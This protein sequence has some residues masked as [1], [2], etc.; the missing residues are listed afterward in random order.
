MPTPLTQ[1]EIDEYIKL[2]GF[3]PSEATLNTFTGEVTPKVK[4]QPALSTPTTAE[5]SKKET[6]L[7]SAALSLGP[8]AASLPVGAAVGMKAAAMSAPL[9]AVP[10]IGPALPP[11]IGIGSGLIAGGLAGMGAGA[12]QQKVLEQSQTGQEFLNRA[13]L[14]R[15]ANPIT[16]AVGDVAGSI[17]GVRP[18]PKMMK[19]AFYALTGAERAAGA[20]LANKLMHPA[21]QEIGISGALGGGMS[22]Y[23]DIQE[24]KDVNVGKAL[25]NTIGQGIMSNVHPVLSRNVPG[26]RGTSYTGLPGAEPRQDMFVTER[27]VNPVEPTPEALNAIAAERAGLGLKLDAIEASMKDVSDKVRLKQLQRE[28]KIKL[29]EIDIKNKELEAREQVLR[30]KVTFEA[31]PENVAWAEQ[32]A[33]VKGV[34]DFEA[35]PTGV[36]KSDSGQSYGEFTIGP[37][38][39]RSIRA[40]TTAAE[41]GPKGEITTTLPE[42]MIQERGAEGST[43]PSTYIGPRATTLVHENFHNDFVNMIRSEKPAQRKMGSQIL[44]AV[45]RSPEFT[46]WK[47]KLS[48][49]ALA[50][51]PDPVEELYTIEASKEFFRDPEN[52]SRTWSGERKALARLQKGTGT[53]QDAV[54]IGLMKFR[55]DRGLNANLANAGATGAKASLASDVSAEIARREKNPEMEQ[56]Q[57]PKTAQ[58]GTP[59][60]KFLRDN[61]ELPKDTFLPKK[62]QMEMRLSQPAPVTKLGSTTNLTI[63]TE[64]N[65]LK[66]EFFRK[67]PLLT[68]IPANRWSKSHLAE[69]FGVDIRSIND[70]EAR[71]KA[72]N[73]TAPDWQDIIDKGQYNPKTQPKMERNAEGKMRAVRDEEGNAVLSDRPMKNVITD[74]T[75]DAVRVIEKGVQRAIEPMKGVGHGTRRAMIRALESGDNIEFGADVDY[76]KMLTN[77]VIQN[78]SQQGVSVEGGKTGN[79]NLFMSAARETQRLLRQDYMA[80]REAKEDAFPKLKAER[81]NRGK[82]VAESDNSVKADEIRKLINDNFKKFDADEIDSDVYESVL[83]TQEAKL[84]ELGYSRDEIM[85]IVEDAESPEFSVEKVL[86]RTKRPVED[87]VEEEV[88]T[89]R[90]ERDEDGAGDDDSETSYSLPASRISIPPVD[91]IFVT[92]VQK[93]FDLERPYGL[94]PSKD[95]KFA[96]SDILAKFRNTPKVE[97]ELLGKPFTDWLTVR[98]RVSPAEVQEWLEKNGPKV[99][100]VNYG[101]EGRVSEAKKEYDRMTHEWYEKLSDYEQKQMRPEDRKNLPEEKRSTAKKYW[102]LMEAIAKEPKD[103]SPRATSYYNTVSAFDTNQPMSEWTATRS[104]KNVQRVDVVI[105]EKDNS[106]DIRELL[107]KQNPDYSDAQIE[108]S[109]RYMANKKEPLWQPDNLHENLPNTLGWAMIQYKDGPNGER[110]A[111]IVEAQS[112]W[113]Q[114]NRASQERNKKLYNEALKEGLDALESA[115]TIY[116][117]RGGMS[118]LQKNGGKN[119][120][121]NMAFSEQHPEYAAIVKDL[122]GG[123]HPITPEI[124]ARL[125]DAAEKYARMM[126][127]H[128]A[129]EAL[130][131]GHGVIDHPLLA[132][133]NRLI[134]KATIDQAR[135]EGATHIMISD[136][137][138]AMITEKLDSGTK[139]VFLDTDK[140]TNKSLLRQLRNIEYTKVEKLNE[141]FLDS[142]ADKAEWE[143]AIIKEE[144]D[145]PRLEGFR[146][147]Y[148]SSYFLKDA[149]GNPL[150]NKG[151]TSSDDAIRYAENV[152]HL[153]PASKYPKDWKGPRDESDY[154]VVQGDLP[155]IAAELTGTKGERVSLGEHKNAMDVDSSTGESYGSNVPRTDLVFT[156]PDGTPKTDVSGMMFD[157]SAPASRREA[158]EKFTLGGRR[159]STPS[160][161]SSLPPSST[162]EDRTKQGFIEAIAPQFYKVKDVQVREAMLN[163]D[164]QRSMY[165]GRWHYEPINEFQS[166]F[167]GIKEDRL[168]TI[169]DR[170]LE[171]YRD[172]KKSLVTSG[173]TPEEV[174]AAKFL[175]ENIF[176]EV[177]KTQRDL[178]MKVETR[179]GF[180][181]EAALS[182]WYVP[183]ML[184]EKAM[185]AF[186][187]GEESAT[188]NHL[189]DIWADHVVKESKGTVTKNEALSEIQSYVA[190]IGEGGRRGTEFGA[191]RK[192]AGYGLP[193]E[194]RERNLLR[195]AQRYSRRAAQDVA[196]F[197]HLEVPEYV[198][199]RLALPDP[200]TGIATHSKSL[201]HLE[202]VRDAMKFVNNSFEIYH[203][204]RIAAFARMVTNGILGPLAG[205]RDFA[206]IPANIAPYV[207]VGDIGTVFKS[208]FDARRDWQKSLKLGARTGLD[209][210]F[211]V[212]TITTID[213]TT[214][215]FNVASEMLRKWQG[216]DAIE[217][218]NRVWTYSIG[219]NLAEKAVLEGNTEF[220]SKFGRLAKDAKTGKYNT[221][222]IAKNFVDRV[223]GTYGGAGLPSSAVDGMAAPWFS[224]ARW[225]LEK[226]NVIFQDVIKPAYR[227][228]NRKIAPLLQYALGAY[229][230]GEM[231]DSLVQEINAG[232]KSNIPTY[233]EL[234]AA[235]A[236]AE[237]YVAKLVNVMQLGSF[238]G[239]A[240]DTLKM[241]MDVYRGENPRGFSVPAATFISEGVGDTL[242][243]FTRAVRDGTDP[244]DAA[245]I[246]MQE[247]LRTQIQ[248]ARLV[249][250]AVD[251]EE[252]DRKNALR[253]LR[254]YKQM[255]GEFIPTDFPQANPAMRPE[256]R[257]LKRANTPEEAREVLP[258]VVRNLMEQHKDNPRELRKAL[259]RLKKNSFQ[260]FPNP[261]NDPVE[262]QQYYKYLVD[263]LGPVEARKRLDEYITQTSLNRAKSAAIP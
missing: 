87:D 138:T 260:T 75:P 27:T 237:S 61:Q 191:L 174:S 10:L 189:M 30:E 160:A 109:V 198:R 26:L 258:R 203:S 84:K 143:A 208:L 103:T 171:T 161:P 101:M 37:D 212:D 210:M 223:Q 21:V 180:R 247:L 77:R 232:K 187:K 56:M 55:Y 71:F 185:K 254:L 248:T 4:I 125:K 22:A 80:L 9:A 57:F 147:N 114:D 28:A 243:N 166:K 151:F 5:P 65:P 246:L 155:S 241:A 205:I 86:P 148:D 54:Q 25:V 167:G 39:K 17:S 124:R 45:E 36:L 186:T 18:S 192:A 140:I 216:R 259:D 72:E 49:E 129:S 123:T 78:L 60:S 172:K 250:N 13:A 134:L 110:V 195:V 242:V 117:T 157:I 91:E 130:K 52:K 255:R 88:G 68:V 50:K 215:A 102:D 53:L 150:T 74:F 115:D 42:G 66:R 178:N 149:E 231:I 144:L 200:D 113:G 233:S 173:L 194:M 227:S 11:I 119:N 69:L 58:E 262:A 98:S 62:G 153:K 263:T 63:T 207:K 136:A 47:S 92:D 29:A 230:T 104:K 251:S 83:N 127:N 34:T 206:T 32:M 97:Q 176:R 158:G 48:P 162:A 46:E 33:R 239:M 14:A 3:D 181:R 175:N 94:Q 120:V 67:Y 133:T 40:S 43:D 156:N 257:E 179:D 225:S 217:Q 139:F 170:V 90:E 132:D 79:K 44:T 196:R 137:E 38:G 41:E 226:S 12:V 145:I 249:M 108:E 121:S 188:A 177:R 59:L 100:V 111:V 112:R 204:P 31:S 184:N 7:R 154:T 141:T 135:K 81:L 213:K 1:D 8:S 244:L 224:L 16:S 105:P 70:F 199:E 252:V 20:G 89:V 169:Y 163:M 240:G 23:E 106:G 152:L 146:F 219:K 142:I 2:K 99:E 128:V 122:P 126:V 164:T 218:V 19:D 64:E 256:E 168:N 82:V 253:D 165:L 211:S 51:M 222:V 220:L 116:K 236:D 183:E 245:G 234:A 76:T 95:G 214:Y 85:D 202:E 229:L 107:K 24:G 182:P 118:W 96:S 190:A 238:A 35:A 201:L 93:Q 159:F 209:P 221:D 197:Q 73:K 15:E 6:F 193:K 228:E 131:Q 261:T 235:D